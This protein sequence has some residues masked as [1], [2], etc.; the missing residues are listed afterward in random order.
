MAYE[1]TLRQ[2]GYVIFP[3]RII[4]NERRIAAVYDTFNHR[5]W[6][7]SKDQNAEFEALGFQAVTYL[8][9]QFGNSPF[10]SL[11]EKGNRLPLNVVR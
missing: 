4:T 3:H 10:E 1:T 5:I 2:E 8:R 9:R 11:K 7:A 6:I